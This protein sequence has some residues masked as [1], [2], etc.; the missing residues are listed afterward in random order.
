LLLF[1][2]KNSPK[3]DIIMPHFFG[4][5]SDDVVDTKK[6]G[7]KKNKHMLNFEA[8]PRKIPP[9]QNTSRHIGVEGFELSQSKIVMR[10]D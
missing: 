6:Q 2:H 1:W 5:R 9:S 4:L 10:S 3:E 8:S 7:E